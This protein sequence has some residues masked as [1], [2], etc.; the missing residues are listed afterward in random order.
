MAFIKENLKNILLGGG[1]GIALLLAYVVFWPSS[2][3]ATL[4]SVERPA[5]VKENDLLVLLLDLKSLQLD[6]SV[7]SDPVFRSLKHFGVDIPPEPVGRS[8]PFAPIGSGNAAAVGGTATKPA[9]QSPS[10]PIN[11]S[12]R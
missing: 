2:D 10:V 9:T 3:G 7:L 1:L 12:P 5:G 8:N 6:D 4:L 11:S